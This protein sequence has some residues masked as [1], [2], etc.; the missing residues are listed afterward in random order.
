[1]S[2][3]ATFTT[4][5]S[6]TNCVTP[7]SA[8]DAQFAVLSSRIGDEENASTPPVPN[9]QGGEGANSAQAANLKGMVRIT[10]GAMRVNTLLHEYQPDMAQVQTACV[11]PF[12]MDRYEVTNAQYRKFW[13]LLTPEDRQRRKAEL[14]PV[15]WA[16]SDPPFPQDLDNAPV[17]G[18]PLSGAQ[19]YAKWA[20][21][22][23]PTPYEWCLAAFGPGGGAQM[24]AWVNRY[25]ADRQATWNRITVAHYQYA[26]QNP[27]VDKTGSDNFPGGEARSA[28][29]WL[30][31]YPFEAPHTLWSRNT[32][33]ALT[34]HLW[35]DWKDPQHILPVGSRKFDASPYGV[36][37]MVFNGAEIVMPGQMWPSVDQGASAD[38]YIQVGFPDLS[39]EDKIALFGDRRIYGPH[40]IHLELA[41]PAATQTGAGLS[42]LP[43]PLSMRR[44]RGPVTLGTTDSGIYAAYR[45]VGDT[46]REVSDMMMPVGEGV[47]GIA[48]GPQRLWLD[49]AYFTTPARREKAYE[50]K[51]RYQTAIAGDPQQDIVTSFLDSAWYSAWKNAVV[52]VHREMGRDVTTTPLAAPPLTPQ[53]DPNLATYLVPGGFRCV[54]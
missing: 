17:L 50:L 38:Y 41:P 12:L 52:P 9:A 40:A 15:A 20:G 10:G 1:M 16:I 53:Q 23:L 8:T 13:Q 44:L 54:R 19:A 27:G 21:K 6:L 48:P 33:L 26:L 35:Q 43:E 39:N 42:V 32:I 2:D 4:L 47:V 29:P 36:M 18:V 34:A 37:D 30:F 22:R 31:W 11:A 46:I 51:Q 25:V 28:L 24:P 5:N 7:Q 49:Y 45:N 14:Y 3:A